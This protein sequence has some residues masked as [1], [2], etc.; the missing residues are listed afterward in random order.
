MNDYKV[1]DYGIFNDAVGTAK[2]LN[3]SLDTSK[4]EID[5]CKNKLNSESVF[6][7]PACDEALKGL[8]NCCSKIELLYDNFNT[9]SGYL[10]DTANN[11]KSG[12][13]EAK[14]NILSINSD[15]KLEVS[16]SSSAS[17]VANFSGSNNEEKMYNYLSSQGFNDAAICGILANINYE[18]GFSTDAVGDGG[19]SYG[20]CQWHEGRWD[21][22]NSYCEENNLDSSSIEGQ[23]QYLLYE[24]QNSYP[25]V[26][27]TLK[28]VPNTSE[29]AYQAAYKWTTDF[30]V[31]ENKE[32]QADI[33]GSSASSTY[34]EQYGSNN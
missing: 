20:I 17:G 1:S 9:I 8:D 33:R 23:G 19:T 28:N 2:K 22:L 25:G 14:V 10:V 6:M 12:D 26:Y 30:E 15:G 5:D 16:S 34:W 31:P 18:S 21:N 3:E 27:D 11:Y 29:G 7:G 13:K 32:S 24:L 4:T